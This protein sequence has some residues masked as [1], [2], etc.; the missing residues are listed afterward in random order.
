MLVDTGLAL[1]STIFFGG[2]KTNN[3]TGSNVLSKM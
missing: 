2:A 3:V 1:F